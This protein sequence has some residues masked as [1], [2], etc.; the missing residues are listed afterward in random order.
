MRNKRVKQIEMGWIVFFFKNTGT[1]VSA[2]KKNTFFPRRTQKLAYA[3][4]LV[5]KTW[6]FSQEL[7]TLWLGCIAQV[8]INAY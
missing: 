6:V 4:D 7:R 3:F 5:S 1:F 2:A 8:L